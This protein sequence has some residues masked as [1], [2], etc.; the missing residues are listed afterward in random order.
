MKYSESALKYKKEFKNVSD[1]V[2]NT[3]EIFLNK[4]FR[5]G[6]S[7]KSFSP[8]FIPGQIYSFYYNTDSEIS[9]KRPF[10]NRNP[11]VLCT[12]TFKKKE[13]GTIL[14]GIDLVTVPPSH[15]IEILSKIY[16][17]FFNVIERNEES[18]KSGGAI[19]PI[20]LKDNLLERALRGTGYSKSMFGFKASFIQD[21][22]I[23]DLEDWYKI[24]YLRYSEIE[25]L[26]LQ[27]IYSEY[28]SKLI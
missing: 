28:E 1:L 18:Y 8:P 23:L 14:K 9:E 27:G 11:I 5:G 7:E 10:I 21:V 15:K 24:P 13:Y 2:S 25:G 17:S 16:D 12:E 6:T 26:D 4:Y 3:D 20:P 22:K 19:T